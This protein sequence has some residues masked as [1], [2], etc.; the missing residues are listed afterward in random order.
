MGQRA[1]PSPSYATPLRVLSAVAGGYF[2]VAAAVPLAAAGLAAAGAMVRSEAVAL[3]SMLGFVAYL[4]LLLWAFAQR[5]LWRVCL[6]TLG[7]AAL[8]QA[9][10]RGLAGGA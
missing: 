1:I 6:V 7:G 2:L 3:C 8:A 10:L 9:A 4:L 5:Q